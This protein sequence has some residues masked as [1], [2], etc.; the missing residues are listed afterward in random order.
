MFF[1]V[2]PSVRTKLGKREILSEKKLKKKRKYLVKGRI[3]T[4]EVEYTRY[5]SLVDYELAVTRAKPTFLFENPFQGKDQLHLVAPNTWEYRDV[6]FPLLKL[7]GFTILNSELERKIETT[8]PQEA[9]EAL[10][11]GH[12]VTVK[13]EIFGSKKVDDGSKIEKEVAEIRIYGVK[14]EIKIKGLSETFRVVYG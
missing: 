8:S 14:A 12:F 5:C 3:L 6:S 7:S 13:G 4:D 2:Q 11:E 1:L 9:F 10:K